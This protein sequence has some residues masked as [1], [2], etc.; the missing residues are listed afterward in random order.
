MSHDIDLI[1]DH[2]SMAAI[3]LNATDLSQSRHL[4][5]ATKWRGTWSGVHLDLYVP[6]QSQLGSHLK[7][8]VEDLSG[9]TE[10]VD[11]RRVLSVGAH[12]ATKWAAL[13]DRQGS[14]R[15]DKDRNEIL[16]LIKQP[17]AREAPRVLIEAS[18]LAPEAVL[19]AIQRGFE[20][21]A[22][23]PQVNRSE[24]TALRRV[25]IE[26]SDIAAAAN[27]A[28][29]HGNERGTAPRGRANPRAAGG[30]APGTALSESRPGART[31][32]PGHL[33]RP[34]NGR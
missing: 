26:W 2:A 20:L 12:I 16:E 19:A 8:R 29:H 30:L 5:G 22:A 17:G 4:A 10:I 25:G 13:L 33:R 1:V 31:T 7:L 18:A 34:E 32:A 6:H 28:A 24:R 11:G 23:S 3:A 15:G 27:P 14:Q 9:H 21:L